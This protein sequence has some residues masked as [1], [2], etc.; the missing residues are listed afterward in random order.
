MGHL[1]VFST[2]GVQST[3]AKT[4]GDWWVLHHR[5]S[6]SWSDV[7]KWV[8]SVTMCLSYYLSAFYNVVFYVWRAEDKF[9]PM[10]DN[11]DIIYSILVYDRGPASNTVST[12]IY[13]AMIQIQ[14]L[15]PTRLQKLVLQPRYPCT[16]NNVQTGSASGMYGCWKVEG[17][18]SFLLFVFD[19]T[20]HK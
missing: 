9:L 1:S 6:V 15:Q 12:S 13:T 8:L 5:Q 3:L 7:F 11:K 20:R 17:R 19:H 16:S 2:Q 4:P 10:V 14:W 18:F